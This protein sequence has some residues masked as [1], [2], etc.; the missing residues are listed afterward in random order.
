[1]KFF[2]KNEVCKRVLSMVLAFVMVFTMFAAQL[3]SG[4]LEVQAAENYDVTVHW[5]NSVNNWSEVKVWAWDLNNTATN[6]T[7]GNWPGKVATANA[8]NAGWYDY[9]MNVTGSIALGVIFNNG[10]GAQTGD[11]KPDLTKGTEIWIS[12]GQGNPVVSYTAPAGWVVPKVTYDV[13]VHYYNSEGF[14]SMNAY[15]WD[16][17][18]TKFLGEWPGTEIAAVAEKNTWYDITLED[19]DAGSYGIIFNGTGGQT[20]DSFI[21]V[22]SGVNEYWFVGN[23]EI[24]YTSEP[25]V[26]RTITVHYYKKN[27]GWGEVRAYC[28]QGKPEAWRTINGYAAEG[29]WPGKAVSTN[30]F[31]KDWYDL[32]ITKADSS[33]L[34][35]VFNNGNGGDGNQTG[36][37]VISAKEEKTECWYTA[38]GQLVYETPEGW[39][40]EATPDDND[41]PQ[42]PTTPSTYDVTLHVYN[43]DG[44]NDLAIYTWEPEI[45]GWPG[46]LFKSGSKAGEWYEYTLEDVPAGTVNFL[47]NDNDKGSKTDDLELKVAEGKT[48]Y[49]IVAGN[50][51][52]INPGAVFDKESDVVIK[53][54]EDATAYT[55]TVHYLNE[56]NWDNVKVYGCENNWSSIA[57]SEQYGSWPGAVISENAE[58]ENWYDFSV[59]KY[60]D[61]NIWCIFNDGNGGEGHQTGNIDVEITGETVEYWYTSEG[62][63]SEK[64]ASWLADGE[65]LVHFY[66][67]ENWEN[68]SLWAFDQNDTK[69]NYT[70]S[71][72]P[73]YTM[74]ANAN[75]ANWYDIL[76]KDVKA[77]TLGVVVN[78][79]NNGLQT[80]DLSIP[81][82]KNIKELWVIGGDR[83]SAYKST[84][85]ASAPELWTNPNAENGGTEEAVSDLCVTDVVEV[86]IGDNVY[87][88]S[89]F[90][91]GVFETVVELEAGTYDFALIVNGV[92]PMSDNTIVLEKAGKIAI[93]LTDDGLS[94]EAVKS[95]AV[96]GTLNSSL[97]ICKDWDTANT[98]AEMTYLGNGL[99]TATLNF[100]AL[101][102]ETA[103]KYKVAF[104]GNWD[105][106][107]GA[108][109]V[110]GSDVEI[111]VPAGATSLTVLVD[112]K[113]AKLY[114][115]VTMAPIKVNG[116]DK[117]PLTT[118][119]SLIGTVREGVSDWEPGVKGFEF[120]RISDTLYRYEK[121][122]KKA[123]AYG[124][125]VVFDYA[126]WYEKEGDQA[127]K[128]TNDNT[129][130]VFLY[131]T[132]S[133]YVYD[134]V[135]EEMTV[136]SL[137]GMS[138]KPA[139]MEVSANE[140]GTVT[141]VATAKAGQ[142]VTLYYGNKAE[143]EANGE[144]VLTEV[145]MGAVS[146][147][148]C[149]SGEVWLG[150]D[151][152]DLV[153]YYDIN[154][155]RKLDESNPIVTISGSDF[156]NF[157]RDAYEG[158]VINVPGTFPGPSW[159]AASNRMTYD[160]NRRYS[161]TFKNV[162]AAKYEFKIAVD[163]SWAENY[164]ANG[165]SGGDNMKVAV[166]STQDVTI[167][168]SDVTHFA[169]NS[170]D[171]KFV[172]ITLSGK[173]IPEGTK[174]TDDGLTG[175][176]SV[177]VTLPAGTYNDVVIN[178]DGTL[179]NVAEFKLDK[180]KAVTFCMD[181]VTSIFYHDASN[182]KIETAKIYFDSKDAEYK[183]V[184]GAIATGEEVT[185]TLA[186]GEDVS[187]ASLV[188][189]GN[190]NK[191]VAMTK[192]GEAAGG[193]QKW[194]ATVSL[195]SIG[196]YGY[197]FV[198][199]NGASVQC[200]GDDDGYYG[201]GTVAELTN[202][203]PYD[204]VVY[205]EGFE[206][207][208]WM[209]NAVIYQIFPDR[210][211]DGDAS[212]NHAQESARGD[213][214]YEFVDNWYT[215]PENPEQ[216]DLLD[217]A[218][219]ESTGALWGDGNW[220][221][222]I[223]GGD[224][225]GITERID[226]LKALGVTVIYLNPVF[227]S[228]SNHRYD[229]CDYTVID[230][231][232][233]TEGDFAELVKVAEKNGMKVVLDGVFNHV[234]DDS[235]YF[236]RYYKFIDKGLDTIGAYPY[237]AF[238]Y[239]YM[240]ENSVSKEVAEKAAKEYFTAEYGI[241]D[242]SY[243]EWFD[244]FQTAMTDGNGK[245]VCD[246]IGQRAGKPVYGYD[247]WWG[248]DSM[249]II[250]ST[251][252]SEYQTGDWAEEIIY[253]AEGT[254]VTQYWISQGMDGWR[255]DVANEVSDETWQR[256]R[257]SV[258]ALNREAVI[259]G[260]IW[261]D[262]TKYILGD[263]YDS[264]MNYMFRNAVTGFAMGTNAEETTKY[265]EKLRERYPEEAFYAMMNLVGSHDTTRILSYLDGIGDDRNQKDINSAFPT[266]EKTSW[267]AKQRQ[268]L[269]AFL[270]FTYAG[271]PTIYYGDEIGMV[272]SDD[273]DDR[274]AF[275]WGKGNKELVTYYATLAEARDSYAALRTGSVETFN[276]GNNNVLAYVR[277]DA[278]NEI[279]VLANN[280]TS[281]VKVTLDLAALDIDADVLADVLG[282]GSYNVSGNKATVTVAARR[283]VILVDDN[284]VKAISVN[285]AALAP[286]YDEAYVV[287]VVSER[288]FDKEEPSVPS[289]PNV[290][291]T[292]SV[293]SAPSVPSTPSAPST[294]VFPT[295]I[296]RPGSVTETTPA[297]EEIDVE[298]E[299]IDTP[300][301]DG[302]TE[303]VTAEE[304]VVEGETEL[305]EVEI[306][307]SAGETSSVMP[308][309]VVLIVL[310]AACGGV[311]IVLQKKK[312]ILK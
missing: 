93:R 217:K 163:G 248:Y 284:A 14:T 67:K 206:T 98:D 273:P 66:N 115:D 276:A 218:T 285:E 203:K 199:S 104:N 271:A 69:I 153:Y 262:A 293:P 83:N 238:V 15:G 137:L 305:E 223:Y 220:S 234:S 244:V 88:M 118:T 286:A 164:G 192:A 150:D 263:M 173:N 45:N 257:E 264:V 19:L 229:A 92:D 140:N 230:P 29:T 76:L 268:Y 11:L 147:G 252:G 51:N 291:S 204:L 174:L 132:A 41:G 80:V 4:L 175:I 172:D 112:E 34:L 46:V 160:G 21:T 303:E 227:S 109:G 23:D 187:S 309:L 122:F 256:F 43:V 120:T 97:G 36:D 72:W 110:N 233:G 214:N 157:V 22:G 235:I 32:E 95:A 74:T 71:N 38:E 90:T 280:S 249:P 100:P 222:E 168:Y 138:A 310:L 117:N 250:K 258:K 260:E 311:I 103:L 101:A 245:A 73:G 176:Y 300:L 116:A 255:L 236:D 193:V 205:E 296:T 195:S 5:N 297:D 207:P 304:E 267:D 181:P 166:P 64:P 306:P 108:T 81:I 77:N 265:M 247:G 191:S 130:V 241:T 307:L 114:D 210:F 216:K 91:G 7:G 259:I 129:K 159:D 185:F 13:T 178:C 274:R 30:E 8:D 301:S 161:Y 152:L 131:D 200:Y 126:T 35:C 211:Y 294:P 55:V 50:I 208:D 20:G 134:S 213:V 2:Y 196:E 231:I 44:W 278:N 16:A 148:K 237:W 183:S 194:N 282:S 182:V 3:P 219:Y 10:N 136:A 113:A 283:G 180:E 184:F 312:A 215:L 202:V 70:G 25:C 48:E 288:P 65:I 232:L 295:L 85:S 143:V 155:T 292:P 224:L 58:H 62:L 119:V 89:P 127:L 243:V 39:K 198:V 269:V 266:Y 240:A 12:G 106:N 145:S 225:E 56:N 281:A 299:D 52:G 111:T 167:Y 254:S 57:G 42:E 107:I 270:Q 26:E 28:M 86:K 251:N 87:A 146:N 24:A 149:S 246:K 239:D 277:R 78:N 253:N 261:D 53:K 18:G 169:V 59:T 242:Y 124:Y 179:Y 94:T 61:G 102:T 128:I 171:Y 228:I 188:I 54:L 133:G 9:S 40:T 170:I 197:Y 17:S 156:S 47:I 135:N 141:F 123:N 226:Y 144:A 68:V 209:K 27:A 298:I 212:N 177:T 79:G 33:D 272:G 60:N 290:P 190:E 142:T 96:V 49:W 63:S 186:T 1:M 308:I 121:N 302:Q 105:Y 75:K 165:V 151:A 125:K 162:P 279:I 31:N 158:R 99:Y 275:E 82:S 84:I 189:K 287:P 154:G 139:E 201:V 6:Y 221:N 37:I 289:T